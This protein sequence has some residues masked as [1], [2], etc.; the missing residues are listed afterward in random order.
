MKPELW[1]VEERANERFDRKS[2]EKKRF[3]KLKRLAKIYKII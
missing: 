1:I 2:I 3:D